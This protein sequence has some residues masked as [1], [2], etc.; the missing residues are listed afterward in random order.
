METIENQI[1]DKKTKEEIIN[2]IK[3][4]DA[5]ALVIYAKEPDIIGI[6]PFYA[7]P[8]EIYLLEYFAIQC[9]LGFGKIHNLSEEETIELF[10]R[11]VRGK[12]K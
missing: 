4:T 8:L 6:A 3:N 12:S 5:P 10:A 11:T 9:V 7:H 1:K 2:I